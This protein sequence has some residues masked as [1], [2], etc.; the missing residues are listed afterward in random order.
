M[1]V[2]DLSIFF[3]TINFVK[4][5]LGMLHIMDNINIICQ[6]YLVE[7]NTF[8]QNKILLRLFKLY[9]PWTKKLCKKYANYGETYDDIKQHVYIGIV[10]GIIKK[11]FGELFRTSIYRNVRQE[12]ANFVI[13]PRQT[14]KTSRCKD[15]LIDDIITFKN[16]QFSFYFYENV[17][18]F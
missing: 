10:N 15:L 6:A 5:N 2:Q 14:Q 13:K 12:I 1:D 4:I 18:V 3:D 16:M 9:V 17:I 7:K 11:K 8:Q